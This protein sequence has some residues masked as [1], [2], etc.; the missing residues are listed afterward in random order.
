[1]C[2]TEES[3]FVLTS[4]HL[5]PTVV[6][7]SNH[8]FPAQQ[9]KAMVLARLTEKEKKL[10]DLKLAA[11]ID[12]P[13][14]RPH[15]H[16]EWK[17]ALMTLEGMTKAERDDYCADLLKHMEYK[18]PEKDR[19]AH[20]LDVIKAA[21]LAAA[22]AKEKTVWVVCMHERRECSWNCGLAGE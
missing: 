17:R 3:N 9:D 6:D 10:Y 20:P 16:K 18:G 22:A 12:E 4:L 2:R 13:M 1:M 8:V 5:F 7:I 19:P 15:P 21:A 14:R 11:Y